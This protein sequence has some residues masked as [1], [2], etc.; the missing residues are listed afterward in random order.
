MSL[1]NRMWVTSEGSKFQTE[2]VDQSVKH[3]R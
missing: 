1:Y 2:G 3:S